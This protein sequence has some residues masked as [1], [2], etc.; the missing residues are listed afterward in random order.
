M[1]GDL[2]KLRDRLRAF[3]VARDW[4]QFHTPKNLAMA[5]T[6]EAAE[7][8]AEL[9]WLTD[10][11]IAERLADPGFRA[12]LEDEI[13]DVF[14]YLVRLADVASIDLISAASAKIDRNEQ[15]Y[16]AD[17]SRGIASKYTDLSTTGG[18]P[19]Q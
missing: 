18:E 10:G 7:L 5:L 1:T 3:T 8:G 14:I 15:R 19:P 13:A 17:H 16:P 9:Q 11:Q 4:G 6:G 2:D 12:R